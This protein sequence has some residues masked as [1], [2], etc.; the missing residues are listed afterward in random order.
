MKLNIGE[1]IKRL[2]KERDLTQEEF[3]EK[4]DI[5][6]QAVSRWENEAA[7]PDAQN[8]LRI[9]KLFNVTTDYL[10]N[11]DNE[12]RADAPAIEIAESKIEETVPLT[13]K[14]KYPYWYLILII[15]LL[16]VAACVIIKISK[17]TTEEHQHAALSSVKENEIRNLKNLEQLDSRIFAQG[18]QAALDNGLWAWTEETTLG[19]L[20][21]HNVDFSSANGNSAWWLRT[22]DAN[23]PSAYAIGANGDVDSSQYVD[24]IEGVRPVVRIRR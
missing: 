22:V 14:K 7:L 6:R 17:S 8:I 16:I 11:E 15:C 10:L 21:F 1:N 23:G 12:D 5:S 4:L 18:T 2:R 9:S 20:K 24:S 19:Y 13:Q 3:A